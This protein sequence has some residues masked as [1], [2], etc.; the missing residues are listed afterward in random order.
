MGSLEIRMSDGNAYVEVRPAPALRRF[1][2]TL[3]VHRIEGPPPPEGRL[4]LP[5]G[6]VHFVWIAELGLRIAGPA[7][8]AMTPPAQERILAFGA[9]F[10]PGAA[11]YLLRTPRPSWSTAT[12]TSTRSTRASPGGWT[13][14]WAPPRTCAPASSRSRGSW[15]AASTAPTTSPTPP[16]A[17]RSRC[18]TAR[19]RPSPARRPGPR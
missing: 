19:R 4:L 13:T 18:W 5:D 2:E 10:H 16:C 1:V 9:T 6:R 12:S 17:R 14:R 3:W 15:R 8:R 11:P 7:R